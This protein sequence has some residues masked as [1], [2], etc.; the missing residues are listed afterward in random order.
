MVGLLVAA[1]EMNHFKG[2]YQPRVIANARASIKQSGGK[3]DLSSDLNWGI[4]ESLVT[5]SLDRIHH[6]RPPGG[7]DAED[8]TDSQRH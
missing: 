6:R 3:I 5:Q 7:V 4:R 1:Y 2:G 8:D